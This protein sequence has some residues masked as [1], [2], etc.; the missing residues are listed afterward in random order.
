M[1]VRAQNTKLSWL[2]NRE[3][4]Y[5]FLY[6]GEKIRNF[7]P[8]IFYSKWEVYQDIQEFDPWPRIINKLTLHFNFFQP[9]KIQELRQEIIYHTWWNL[10]IR[11]LKLARRGQKYKWTNNKLGRDI[12]F[13]PHLGQWVSSP[14][15]INLD[16]GL[17]A[18]IHPCNWCMVHLP[19]SWGSNHCS[20]IWDG[21][22]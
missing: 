22:I 12:T 18:I 3:K 14:W 11:N 16:I 21:V 5:I 1:I 15:V 4:I 6:L 13:I 7:A 8:K 17:E 19:L 2:Q 20:L 9:K 10:E